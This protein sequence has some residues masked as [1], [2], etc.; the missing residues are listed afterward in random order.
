MPA[1]CAVSR[2]YTPR[3]HGFNLV[4]RLGCY[5]FIANEESQG[6]DVAAPIGSREL[7]T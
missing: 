1:G 7:D 5:E 6:L 3:I 2:E 4:P